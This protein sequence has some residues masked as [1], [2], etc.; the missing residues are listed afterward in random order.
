[1]KAKY[2]AKY[3]EPL[4]R[5]ILN[6]WLINCHFRNIPIKALSELLTWENI[7]KSKWSL[8]FYNKPKDWQITEYNTI[9]I[10]DHWNFTTKF[11]KHCQTIQD[12]I[13]QNCWAKGI[14]NGE[15]FDIVEI[16]ELNKE[17]E[18]KDWLVLN[19]N[20]KPSDDK[21]AFNRYISQQVDKGT[22]FYQDKKTSGKVIQFGNSSIRLEDK[23]KLEKF[24]YTEY[25]LTIDGK[26][27]SNLDILQKLYI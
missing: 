13:G 16:Y 11:G 25:K 23:T 3:G 18:F 8:S 12:G 27:Y 20:N 1:M 21:I 26:E 9:R 19:I 4:P 7:F 2:K 14:W 5:N 24:R 6:N 10:S 22:V 15:K 17:N